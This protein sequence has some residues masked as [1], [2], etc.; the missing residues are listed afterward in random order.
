MLSGQLPW[1]WPWRWCW[2]WG[3]PEAAAGSSEERAIAAVG[4]AVAPGWLHAWEAVE[5]GSAPRAGLADGPLQALW[6][7]A[8]WHLIM[9]LS[10]VW[11]GDENEA[12]DEEEDGG[13]AVSVVVRGVGCGAGLQAEAAHGA[14]GD[15]GDMLMGKED[16]FGAPVDGAVA[17]SVA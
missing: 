10:W 11:N 2:G 3:L 5:R 16:G 7:L 8:L 1:P 15:W 12:E 6:F 9:V 13:W 17:L 4:S 14:A